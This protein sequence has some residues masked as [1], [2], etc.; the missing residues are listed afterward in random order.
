MQSEITKK[1]K[2]WG[3]LFGVPALFVAGYIYA[4]L[5]SVHD[6]PLCAV[7][8]FLGFDCPGCGMTRAISSLT[9]LN[10]R[11]SI[12]YHPLGIIVA[13]WL[14]YKFIQAVI[15]KTFKKHVSLGLSDTACDV[16]LYTFLAAIFAQWILRVLIAF[17]YPMAFPVHPRILDFV[18]FAL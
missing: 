18:G 17:H 4:R 16:I 7:K 3:F 15:L 2:G 5:P 12:D 8:H 9:L 14:I 6:L 11:S 13:G 1:M 10:F